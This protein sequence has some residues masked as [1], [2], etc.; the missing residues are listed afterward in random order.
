MRPR[1]R[2]R[3]GPSSRRP[4]TAR[5]GGGGRG[6]SPGPARRP[7]P[8]P[9]ARRFASRLFPSFADGLAALRGMAREGSLPDLAYLADEEETRFAAASAGI[10]P[11][12][13]PG[14]VAGVGLGLLRLRG[15]SMAQGSLLLMAFEGSPARVAH[16]R[17]RALRFARGAASLGASPARRGHEERLEMPHLRDSLLHHRI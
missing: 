4:C 2:G 7:P 13:R 5:G 11:D 16:R 15:F 10:P 8:P 1:T 9:P 12:G 17:R 3:A 14:G 6:V